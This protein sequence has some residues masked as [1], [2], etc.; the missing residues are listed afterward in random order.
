MSD[1]PEAKPDFPGRVSAW[2]ENQGYPLEMRVAAAFSQSGFRVI[3]A[4]YYADP[5]SGAQ[6]EI[7]VVASQQRD[8]HGVLF[9]V[10]FVV[11]CKLSRDKPW[12]L[13]SAPAQRLSDRARVA[14]RASSDNGADLLD[15]I[16]K[17]EDVQAL[18]LFQIGERSAYGV[19]QAF[20]TGSDVTFSALLGATKAASA[21]AEASNRASVQQG[22]TCEIIFPVIVID[23]AL[24]EYY[25]AKDDGPLL[26]RIADGVLAWRNPIARMP[27]TFVHIVTR[28]ALDQFTAKAHAGARHLLLGC[29]AEIRRLAENLSGRGPKWGK[30]WPTKRIP[31]TV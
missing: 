5:E 7:D 9:R 21:E 19:T 4:D 28:D 31:P 10:S 12:V 24:F 11:E 26:G 17:R 30:P 29:D 25:L 3:Q 14:Q 8:V 20:T 13:F 15:E 1:T 16:C 23:G 27:H 18:E 6:R 22:W 2:L